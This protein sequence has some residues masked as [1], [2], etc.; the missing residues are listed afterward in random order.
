MKNLVKV[1]VL[2]VVL[3]PLF[4]SCTTTSTNEEQALYEQSFTEGDDGSVEEKPGN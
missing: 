2:T 3:T 4:A 1:I